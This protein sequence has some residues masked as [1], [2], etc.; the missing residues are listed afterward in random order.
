MPYF[1]PVRLCKLH[2]MAWPAIMAVHFLDRVP[3]GGG[4]GG[5]GTA[6]MIILSS[7]RAQVYDQGIPFALHSRPGGY[8][9]RWSTHQRRWGGLLFPVYIPLL[10]QIYVFI[11]IHIH[12]RHTPLPFLG[13]SGRGQ[14]GQDPADRSALFLKECLGTDL[15]ANILVN[16][17]LVPCQGG[18]HPY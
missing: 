11:H 18:L 6:R 17:H 2:A 3:C 5:G 1:A 10:L 15:A 14:E 12:E 7:D 4:G 9:R 16:S 8:G 13:R